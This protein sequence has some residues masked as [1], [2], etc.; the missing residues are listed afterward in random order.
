VDIAAMRELCGL[1]PDYEVWLYGSRARGDADATSDTDL[2][3]VGDD[4]DDVRAVLTAVLWPSASVSFY[5]W[6][7][8]EAM[9][10]YGSL[11]LDHIRSEARLLRPSPADPGRLRSLLTSLPRFARARHDLEAFRRAVDEGEAS[12]GDGGWPDLELQ[13]LATVA[14]HAVILACHCVDEPAFGRTHPFTIYGRHAGWPPGD[15]DALVRGSVAYRFTPLGS[16]EWVRLEDD[17]SRWLSLVHRVIVARHEATLH[18]A[19]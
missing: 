5:T 14:R 2:L 17:A 4:G 16:P 9:W 7:E 6:S 3:V 10:T 8:I 18:T 12:L 11:F 13:I 19:A 15:I 1:R